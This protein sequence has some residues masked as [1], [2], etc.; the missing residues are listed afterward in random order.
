M[1]E[2]DNRKSFIYLNV[3][4]QTLYLM[5]RLYLHFKDRRFAFYITITYCLNSYT[6][7]C[8]TPNTVAFQFSKQDAS[9]VVFVTFVY[10]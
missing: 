4:V 9:D 7:L 6:F 8:F 2:F 10:S 1:I 5:V 3:M